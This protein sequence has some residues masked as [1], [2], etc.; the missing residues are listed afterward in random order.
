[1]AS[2]LWEADRVR[3]AR[4]QL[5]DEW[6]AP[7]RRTNVALLGCEPVLYLQRTVTAWLAQLTARYQKWGEGRGGGGGGGHKKNFGFPNGSY[8][9]ENQ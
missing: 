4:D 3:A 2:T 8:T 7:W 5:S 9:R 6:P 1:M